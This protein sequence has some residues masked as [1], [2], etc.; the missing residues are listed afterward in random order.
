M[1]RKTVMFTI[2]ILNLSTAYPME[3]V[4]DSMELSNTGQ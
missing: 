1:P 3:I 4:T 2:F